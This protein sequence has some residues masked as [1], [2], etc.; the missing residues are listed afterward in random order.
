[1]FDIVRRH[2]NIIIIM[3]LFKILKKRNLD[4]YS[5][6]NSDEDSS[7]YIPVLGDAASELISYESS[8][9]QQQ[10]TQLKSPIGGATNK[11]SNQ[12]GNLPQNNS[13]SSANAVDSPAII[14]YYD[15]NRERVSHVLTGNRTTIG[16]RAT[17]D[18]SFSS[19][20]K[21]SK[22]HAIIEHRASDRG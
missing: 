18:I 6:S 5:E 16:R 2:T 17:N 19:K 21:I 8:D 20:N 14:Y 10:S 4:G 11:D 12:S 13:K 15:D 7:G 1:M 9:I 3:S 22:E